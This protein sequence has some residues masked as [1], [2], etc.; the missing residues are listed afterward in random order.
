[1]RSGV[2]FTGALTASPNVDGLVS[3]TLNPGLVLELAANGEHL[4]LLAGNCAMDSQ[5]KFL[6]SVA[7]AI[8]LL[9]PATVLYLL[10]N[11]WEFAFVTTIGKLKNITKT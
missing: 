10:D 5:S 1:M 4:R 11:V 6:L 3:D 9:R 2:I 8:F 7:H